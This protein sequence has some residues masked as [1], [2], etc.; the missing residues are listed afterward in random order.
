VEEQLKCI[1]EEMPTVLAAIYQVTGPAGPPMTGLAI[2]AGGCAL[3]A[4]PI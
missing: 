2:P 3:G 4:K 1:G